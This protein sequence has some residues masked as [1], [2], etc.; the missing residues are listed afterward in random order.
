VFPVLSAQTCGNRKPRRTEW[1]SVFIGGEGSPTLST[2]D[3]SRLGGG[4]AF[5]A[6]TERV[7]EAA[8]V[9]AVPIFFRYISVAIGAL[10]AFDFLIRNKLVLGHAAR[11]YLA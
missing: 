10:E 1:G 3:V 8:A 6:S 4:P 5:G 9:P 11:D 7:K 2:V